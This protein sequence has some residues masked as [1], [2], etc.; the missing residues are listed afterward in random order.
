MNSEDVT[1][2]DLN[3]PYTNEEYVNLAFGAKQQGIIVRPAYKEMLLHDCNLVEALKHVYEEQVL[4]RWRPVAWVRCHLQIITCLLGLLIFLFILLKWALP[5]LAPDFADSLFSYFHSLW[6]K[7][8]VCIQVVTAIIVAVIGA[9]FSLIYLA[10]LF[11][12]KTGWGST[13][14]FKYERSELQ[15]R[16][17]EQNLDILLSAEA[18]AAMLNTVMDDFPN[19]GDQLRDPAK[20]VEFQNKIRNAR[21]NNAK[22]P[23]CLDKLFIGEKL[24]TMIYPTNG[25]IREWYLIGLWAFNPFKPTSKYWKEKK[26]YHLFAQKQFATHFYDFIKNQDMPK[27][28]TSLNFLK[29]YGVNGEFNTDM[30]DDFMRDIRKE[31]Q[32]ASGVQIIIQ[33]L[34]S[35]CSKMQH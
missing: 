25:D 35:Q 23:V 22:L 31:G 8:P 12:I 16:Y 29:Q 32:K 18:P 6:S 13:I 27:L 15:A 1:L 30:L 14:Y 24:P 28:T 10:I 3:Y 21:D 5:A 34:D 20:A 19:Y 4:G 17:S 11:G 9:V 33:H 2:K 26:S 7:V